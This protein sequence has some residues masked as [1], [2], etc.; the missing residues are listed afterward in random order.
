MY[1][2]IVV[3][4]RVA[5]AI[6]AALLGRRGWRVLLVDR[7]ALPS[8]AV[9]THFFGPTVLDFLDRDFGVLDD[10]LAA[11]AP[12]LRRW[13]I[14]VAGV[15]Y[16]GPMLP[17]PRHPYNMCVRREVL[18]DVLLRRA[19]AEKGVELWARRP[20]RWLLWDGGRCVGVGG[21]GWEEKAQVVIGADG[22]GSTV[23]RLAGAA[24]AFDAG[25]LRCTQHAYWEDVAPFPEPALELWYHGAEVVQMG[26]CDR[27]AWTIM[28]SA[29]Q[30][31]AAA[32]RA[33]GEAGYLARLA[34]MPGMR[35]RLATARRV[36][37]VYT[38]VNLR[39]YQRTPAGRG[40]LLAGD[41]VCHKD[42]LYGAGIADCVRAAR[43]A[44]AALDATLGGAASWDEATAQYAA[45]IDGAVGARLRAGLDALRIEPI[46]GA[47]LAWV[48]GAL[49]HPAL[50]FDL[51]R[52]CSELFS[53]LPADRRLFWQQVAHHT[54]DVLGLPPPAPVGGA[55]T[56]AGGV[57]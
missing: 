26:P 43:A 33:R 36:S 19:L 57:S 27:G 21:P 48:R 53:G 56:P 3:G 11:G 42:P 6:T 30:D 14:E 52:H 5:G 18:D 37:P 31:A 20:V 54:A 16:G 22:R 9:S 40:W 17:G 1:D 10:L 51:A 13:H 50:A 44:A 23:A 45:Q 55:G 25:A 49:A 39:N 35:A 4:A 46:S 29:P 38:C 8:P 32:V 2:V 47:Q 12:R 34:E 28:I 24:M 15:C 41:A 7:A